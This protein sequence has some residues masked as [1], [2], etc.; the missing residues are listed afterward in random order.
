[1]AHYVNVSNTFTLSLE[2]RVKLLKIKHS[3][4][5]NEALVNSPQSVKN[6]AKKY[7]NSE[8]IS[9]NYKLNIKYIF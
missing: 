3:F 6:D 2:L 4:K 5:K 9:G 1:M 7:S 8:N